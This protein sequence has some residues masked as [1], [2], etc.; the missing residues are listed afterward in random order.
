MAERVN[1]HGTDGGHTD[2]PDAA[3]C[4]CECSTCKRV[5]EAAGRPR[6][7]GRNI[8][9]IGGAPGVEILSLH[10]N[11]DIYVR[12]KLT[13]NDQEVVDGLRAFLE[14]TGYIKQRAKA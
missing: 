10:S 3:N 2:C 11:G 9:T 1:I 4:A 12:G 13:T 14:E 5:W 6:P 8:I 7:D